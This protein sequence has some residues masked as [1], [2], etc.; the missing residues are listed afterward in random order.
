MLLGTRADV[1]F[2]GEMSHHEVLAAIATGHNVVLC[3]FPPLLPP[4]FF[5]LRSVPS[6]PVP[7][8][9]SYP[10]PLKRDLHRREGT[11]P[12]H[13]TPHTTHHTPHR[14]LLQIS[15]R[16]IIVVVFSLIFII[17]RT[18]KHRTWLPP[19]LESENQVP[20]RGRSFHRRSRGCHCPSNPRGAYQSGGSTSSTNSVVLW[21]FVGF[22]TSL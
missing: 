10:P 13:H 16:I 7:S 12:P 22:V 20:F 4:S 5:P 21:V 18:Y 14:T 11:T 1:Y 6:F 15:S 3:K 17:R 8:F 9:P 19:N 2:T